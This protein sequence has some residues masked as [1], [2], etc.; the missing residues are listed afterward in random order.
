MDIWGILRAEKTVIVAGSWSSDQIAS[1]DFPLSKKRRQA[2]PLSR[3]WRWQVTRFQAEGR[4]FRLLAAYHKVVPEF[5]SVLAEDTGNDCRI[6]M[7]WEYHLTHGGWHAHAC[8]G[9]MDSV[10]PGIARPFGIARLPGGRAYHR[11][12]RHLNPGFPMDDATATAIAF[13]RFNLPQNL[14]IFVK[15]AV[16][17]PL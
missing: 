2:Y 10:P 17:W 3:Q 11:R 13:S 14:D 15:N 7:V 4:A 16:P 8:C 12:T 9:P 5:S 6:L 1:K